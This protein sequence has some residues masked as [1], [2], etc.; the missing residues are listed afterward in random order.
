MLNSEL[1]R[2]DECWGLWVAPVP[3][4]SGL[5]STF[6]VGFSNLISNS[7]RVAFSLSLWFQINLYNKKPKILSELNSIQPLLIYLHYSNLFVPSSSP[8]HPVAKN[9]ILQR[10]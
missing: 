9:D 7:D 5:D 10:K 8:K 4:I 1:R 6:I 3:E 2:R